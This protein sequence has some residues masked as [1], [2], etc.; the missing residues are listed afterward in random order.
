M[1]MRLDQG[2][3]LAAGLLWVL[4]CLFVFGVLVWV[5]GGFIFIG[6]LVFL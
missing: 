5:L 2:V 3:V 1:Q 4:F 6:V